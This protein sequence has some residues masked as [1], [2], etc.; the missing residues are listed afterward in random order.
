[1]W[2]V[3]AEVTMAEQ[4]LPRFGT[5]RV[6]G[7]AARV[8]VSMRFAAY[9]LLTSGPLGAPGVVAHL[10]ESVRVVFMFMVDLAEAGR[11]L[12]IVA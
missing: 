6:D 1:M 12:E 11:L 4:A 5:D 2:G 3:G 10:R 7:G 9:L 8:G